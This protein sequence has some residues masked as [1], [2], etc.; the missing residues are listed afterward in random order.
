M[1]NNKTRCLFFILAIVLASCSSGTVTPGMTLLTGL[2][3]YHDEMGQLE[4]QTARWPERQRLGASIKTTYLVTMG[5]SKEFNRLVELDVRR[6]EYLITL[7]GSSLRPD[8][9]AEIKQELVKMNE[10]IDGLTTIVKGQV[11]RSTVPGPEPRQVIESVATI[12]LLYLAIDTFS[13][14]LAPDAAIAPTVKVGSYTVIDQ[15]KFAMVRTPEGQTF[16][17]TT[18]VVQEQGAG[19]SCGTLGR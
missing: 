4:G 11:A 19:I 15:K 10:D 14:T 7:R 18:I 1:K 9:A 6:R 8:R 5:G 13:S 3:G 2:T 12:G 16:Q 17:C